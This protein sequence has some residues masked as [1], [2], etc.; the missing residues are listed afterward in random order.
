MPIN[1]EAL[2]DKVTIAP[3]KPLITRT[4]PPQADWNGLHEKCKKAS[5]LR[6]PLKFVKSMVEKPTYRSLFLNS[7]LVRIRQT[8]LIFKVRNS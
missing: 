6:N 1:F 7:R 3:L 5:N 4:C 2:A 8:N